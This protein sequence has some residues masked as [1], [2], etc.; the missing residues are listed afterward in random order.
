MTQ[1]EKDVAQLQILLDKVVGEANPYVEITLQKGV[2]KLYTEV[3]LMTA[4]QL[5]RIREE[6]NVIELMVDGG[7]LL[8]TGSLKKK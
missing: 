5:D 2:Y 8:L 7:S 6:V 4:E 3:W 1:E